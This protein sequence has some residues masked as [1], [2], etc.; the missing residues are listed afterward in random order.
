MTYKG[1]ISG[2]TDGVKEER[3]RIID[4]L[5]DDTNFTW[6]DQEGT[7]LISEIIKEITGSKKGESKKTI[8]WIINYW[9]TLKQ[10]GMTEKQFIIRFDTYLKKLVKK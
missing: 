2:F 5:L 8:N 6:I 10:Q 3:K 4:I 7:N 9:K 1:Y